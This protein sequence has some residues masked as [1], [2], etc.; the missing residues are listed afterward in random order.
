A[1]HPADGALDPADLGERSASGEY[2]GKLVVV[3]E[4]G[5]VAHVRRLIAKRPAGLSERGSL[6]DLERLL[7][8]ADRALEHSTAASAAAEGS[9]KLVAYRA[10]MH[11][12]VFELMAEGPEARRRAAGFL[13]AV[14]D[15]GRR[16]NAAVERSMEVWLRH[17]CQPCPAAE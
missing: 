10:S 1:L 5:G 15:H 2:G 13:S 12:G 7:D 14:R 9:A 4:S 17:N 6:Q 8:H 3:C 16:H 11:S